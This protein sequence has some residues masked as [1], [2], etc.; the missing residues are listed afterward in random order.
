VKQRNAIFVFVSCS[1]Q[2]NSLVQ[3][4]RAVRA[5]VDDHMDE[6]I[7]S[8]DNGEVRSS[9]ETDA[10]EV[11]PPLLHIYLPLL[12]VLFLYIDFYRVP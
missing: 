2:T 5:L 7:D 6:M 9:E 11:S 4:S 12:F 1:S 3:I 10:L 8:E